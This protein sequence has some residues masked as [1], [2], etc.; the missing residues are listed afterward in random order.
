MVR[1]PRIA[2]LVVLAGALAGAAAPARARDVP[3]P[4]AVI[5]RACL[6]RVGQAIDQAAL[7]EALLVEAGRR[8]A[9]WA[10][11]GA[12]AQRDARIGRIL[13]QLR[14]HPDSAEAAHP[15]QAFRDLEREGVVARL[16]RIAMGAAEPAEDAYLIAGAIQQ[17]ETRLMAKASEDDA[18]AIAPHPARRGFLFREEAPGWTFTCRPPATPDP[19]Y[20]ASAEK[21]TAPYAWAI[22]AKPEELALTGKDR[23][24]AGAATIAVDR[25]N[26]ILD[27]GSIKKVSNFRIDATLGYRITPATSADTVYLYDRY[28]LSR[29]RTRPLPKLD[30]GAKESD[31]DTDA[32]EAGFLTSAELTPN[33]AAAKLF[34]DA[35]AATVYDFAK[36]G[37][38][39]K[40]AMLF[41]PVLDADIGI[42]GLESYG[43]KLG[44]LKTRCRLQ[45]DLEASRILRR[46][47]IERGDYDNFVALGVRPSFEAFVPTGGETALLGSVN[48]R[49][50]PILDGKPRHIERLDMSLKFRFWTETTAGVDIGFAYSKGRNELSYEKEDVL[51]IG[52]GLIY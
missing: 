52:L 8:P 2:G 29:S 40:G 12:E 51:S 6:G 25:T 7:G 23:K 14:R 39:L 30:P 32:F 1:P 19:G 18:F 24:T 48:Y 42:C 4:D 15:D 27:D 46:G 28:V 11:Q 16:G 17:L 20:I 34:V 35:K 10:W 5:A 36:D 38:R 21:V 47:R 13:E 26:T 37:A 49:I 44:W 3:A 9:D 22:R 43:A 33:A 50:L 31:G 41:R 45:I